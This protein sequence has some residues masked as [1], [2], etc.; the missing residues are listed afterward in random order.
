MVALGGL[1]VVYGAWSQNLTVTGNVSTATFDVHFTQPSLGPYVAGDN[2]VNCTGVSGDGTAALSGTVGSVYPGHGCT[3]TA[4]IDNNSTIP[5][6]IQPPSVNA[7]SWLSTSSSMTANL[8]LANK[9]TSAPQTFAV[10]ANDN[11]GVQTSSASGTATFTMVAGQDSILQSMIKYYNGVVSVNG[12]PTFARSTSPFTG[13]IGTQTVSGTGSVT[14]TDS[15]EDT[16]GI[17]SGFDI[18]YGKWGDLKART[19]NISG[20][21]DYAVNLWFDTSGDKEFFDWNTTVTPQLYTGLSGDKVIYSVGNN[22]P[23]SIVMSSVT[24][25]SG[26]TDDTL[27]AIWIGTGPG[28]TATI[29]S[30]TIN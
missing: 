8:S 25:P 21:G 27:V 9:S 3:F 20:T 23:S 22:S 30:V 1:G 28:Q 10:Y 15:K 29:N 7:P 13:V 2:T 16:L 5:V 12:T 18:Y 17:Y 19:V 6:V 11:L 24:A 26:V 14:V 4:E